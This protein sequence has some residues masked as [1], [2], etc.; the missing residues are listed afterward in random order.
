[1][2]LQITRKCKLQTVCLVPTTNNPKKL[3]L[4][5]TP[6]KLCKQLNSHLYLTDNLL[7]VDDDADQYYRDAYNVYCTTYNYDSYYC[8]NLIGSTSLPRLLMLKLTCSFSLLQICLILLPTFQFCIVSPFFA[9]Q[10][11]INVVGNH[12]I[13][14]LKQLC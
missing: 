8:Y 1:M 10:L 12:L 14:I 11:V 3:P 6:I 2:C 13:R 9:Y 7:W 5:P 4:L